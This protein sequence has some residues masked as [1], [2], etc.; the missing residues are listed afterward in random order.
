[1]K[2]LSLPLLLAAVAAAEPAARLTLDPQL[3]AEALR[4]VQGGTKPPV[5]A[6]ADTAKP[7]VAAAPG[8]EDWEAAMQ[9]AGTE[10][11]TVRLL[12]L[13]QRLNPLDPPAAREED[14]AE[15]LRLHRLMLAGNP[16]ACATLGRAFREGR[17]ENGL[18]FIQN[19]DMGLR[20]Q[21]R[22]QAFQLPSE[23][24]SLPGL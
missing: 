1:M 5:E 4:E 17:F 11:G 23:V 18:L 6:P 20:L 8:M 15:V 24:E 16:R 19:E 9:D 14:Y 10:L 22:S 12:V 2:A 7:D 13:M 21:L 3:Y